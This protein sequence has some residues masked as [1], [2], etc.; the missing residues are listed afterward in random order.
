MFAARGGFNYKTTPITGGG[1]ISMFND[2]Y[3][4]STATTNSTGANTYVS[5]S[6]SATSGLDFG[7]IKLDTD[8]NIQWQRK[9]ASGSGQT[10]LPLFSTIDSSENMY[11][12]GYTLSVGSGDM[13][14]TKYNSS[15][16]LQWQRTL[17]NSTILERFTSIAV[18]S[19]GGNVFT[20]GYGN[21]TSYI[22]KYNSSGTIQFQKSLNHTQADTQ[23]MTIDSSNNIY[24]IGRRL[25]GSNFVAVVT[26]L[27][28]TGTVT[29]S[30]TLELSGAD[31]TG[32]AIAVDSSNNT[33]VCAGKGSAPATLY[34]AKLDST[35]SIVWQK[36]TTGAYQA[37]G[38]A[39]DSSNNIYVTAGGATYNFWY[40]KF[41]NSGVLQWQRFL[42]AGSA[43]INSSDISYSNGNIYVTGRTDLPGTYSGVVL[44]T[45]DAGSTT[46]TFTDGT[47]TFSIGTPSASFSSGSLTVASTTT[48]VANTTLTSA[49]ST[50]ANSA[51]SY[52]QVLIPT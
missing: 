52:T 39:L 14:L 13:I 25:V 18:E 40:G 30:T 9:L 27:S 43:S 46:G 32:T 28:N 4:S 5:V 49:T 7:F 35:G 31:I 48:T 44:K 36:E 19:G 17:G 21:N 51:S 38:I 10:D 34:L 41:N 26:K 2:T 15:G 33:Y 1:F 23:Y 6:G 22:S 42:A 20:A 37:K 12:V 50:L 16:N 47:Y 8:G 45:N 29:W 24:I 3:D 11:S